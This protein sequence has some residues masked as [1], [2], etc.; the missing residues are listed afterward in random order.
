MKF[1]PNGYQVA[2]GSDDNSVKIWDLRKKACVYTVPAHTKLVSDIK[3]DSHDNDSTSRLMLTASY[4]HKIKLWSAAT[5]DWILV[6]TLNGGHENKITS[7]S[8]T[9]DMKYIIS[10]SFDRTFKLWEMKANN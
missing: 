9:K 5:G 3:F 7:V 6:R 8:H 10:T 1:L 4:D 2:T